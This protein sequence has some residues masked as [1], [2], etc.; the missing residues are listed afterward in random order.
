MPE[1]VHTHCLYCG[2]ELPPPAR[3]GGQR[4]RYCSDKHRVYAWKL[5]KALR[6][7]A[8]RER[9]TRRLEERARRVALGEHETD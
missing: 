4:R 1:K 8:A 3:T 2:A 5:R 6:E 9:R 7:D